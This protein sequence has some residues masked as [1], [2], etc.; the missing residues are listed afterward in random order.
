[1]KAG[2]A[3]AAPAAACLVVFLSITF[4]PSFAVA[5][6]QDARCINLFG[7]DL[8]ALYNV[9]EPFVNRNCHQIR[10]GEFF[11]ANDHILVNSQYSEDL[12][13]QLEATNYH[14]VGATPLEDL[15]AKIV[16]LRLEVTDKATGRIQNF[17]FAANEVSTTQ[18]HIHNDA[19]VCADFFRSACGGPVVP[20]PASSPMLAFIP[21]VHPL[22][23]GSYLISIYYTFSER[24]N[25]GFGT[26]Q[27]NFFAPG[28][29]LVFSEN[30]FDVVKR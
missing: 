30:F 23:P 20:A 22:P 3:L 18:D 5:D 12:R 8:N 2:R 4:A 28:E 19:L 24:Y 15:Q 26:G 10:V 7:V 27:P 13:T 17:T 6:N 1:M 11:I 9:T 29:T 16:S 14:F 25:N 21:K